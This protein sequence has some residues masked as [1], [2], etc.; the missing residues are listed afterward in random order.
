MALLR[1]LLDQN[2]QEA[3]REFLVA[4]GYD[5]LRVRDTTGADAP[6]SLI[7]F[8]A[9]SEGCLLITHDRHFRR[10]SRL[11]TGEQ[12]RQFEAGAGH[13]V[14]QVRENRSVERLQVEWR[15]ILYHYADA[16][17]NG[18]RFQVVLTATGFQVVT[19][20]PVHQDEKAPEGPEA[21][22]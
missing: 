4:L 2:V 5:V 8:V 7:A 21:A 3:V 15:H 19:N 18:L 20:A 6:E 16:Q 12:R 9:K 13:I 11:L 1:F 10:F 22:G 17:E 14:L